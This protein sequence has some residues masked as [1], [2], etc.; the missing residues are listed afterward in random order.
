MYK[1]Y[2][3]DG[4]Y[5]NIE[6]F[7]NIC[8]KLYKEDILDNASYEKC[9]TSNIKNSIDITHSFFSQLTGNVL[10]SFWVLCNNYF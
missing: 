10:F 5:L 1:H 8:D 6:L 2:T 3:I 7:D 9:K 4:K